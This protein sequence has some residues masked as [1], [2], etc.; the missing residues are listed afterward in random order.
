MGDILAQLHQWTEAEKF[1][2]AALAVQSDHVPAHLSYGNMLARNVSAETPPTAPVV[3]ISTTI[4]VITLFPQLSRV[5]EAEQWFKRALQIS[6]LDSS[7]HHHYG[8]LQR[9][10]GESSD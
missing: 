10:A 7:V 3:F 2:K 6:P 9:Q 8:E 5:S 4:P 1:H